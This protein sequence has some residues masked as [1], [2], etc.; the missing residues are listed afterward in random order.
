[1][2]IVAGGTVKG[3]MLALVAYDLLLLQRVAVQT[4][5]SPFERNGQ[6]PVG[7]SVTV[8]ASGQFEMG[9]P[10]LE[11]ALGAR[12]DRILEFR[13]MTEMTAHA[14][15]APVLPSCLLNVIHPLV[16]TFHAFFS[17]VFGSYQESHEFL[18]LRGR[19]HQSL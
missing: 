10:R 7:I 2:G 6:R 8:Q 12:R 18:Y 5:V 16:M 1:M 15:N 19:G 14:G 9:L 11:V 13:R 17:L 3:G 4:G